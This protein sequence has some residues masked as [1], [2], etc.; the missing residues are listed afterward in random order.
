MI[1]NS[2]KVSL[3]VMF[4]IQTNTNTVTIIVAEEAAKEEVAVEPTATQQQDENEATP[5]E[6]GG[7]ASRR[8]LSNEEKRKLLEQYDCESEGEGEEEYLL[9]PIYM[10][11]LIQILIQI[12][13]VYMEANWI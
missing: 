5:R 4:S 13:C 10:G 6:E 3:L 1:K 9:S 8:G 12:G 2:N 7:M 11:I